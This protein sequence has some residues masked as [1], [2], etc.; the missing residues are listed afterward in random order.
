MASLDVIGN[1]DQTWKN[2]RRLR[3][4]YSI[5]VVPTIHFGAVPDLLDRYAADGVDFV[6]LGGM[7]GHKSSVDKLMR[8]T[9]SVFR[10][11][12]DNYPGMRFHGW[13][14]THQKLLSSLPWFSVDSSGI[15]AAYRYGR[16]AIWDPR[17][18]TVVSVAM[19]GREMYRHSDL[20]R[21]YYGIS[22]ADIAESTVDTRSMIIR[23]MAKS[24][25]LREDWLRTRHHVTAPMY[26]LQQT[27]DGNGMHIHYA[28]S[29]PSHLLIVGLTR[30]PHI[31]I[32]E[33]PESNYMPLYMEGVPDD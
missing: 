27:A 26:G 25:Q 17:T 11:A 2:Y 19:N 30:G 16:A 4:R 18:K 21:M 7:V 29:N 23:T 28:D 15:G 1:P 3:H 32:S 9:L 22:P 5:D 24:V 20:L 33:S 10:Y 12:R 6:G 31:H 13:G 8:W 14:V